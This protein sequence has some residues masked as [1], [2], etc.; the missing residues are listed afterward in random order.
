[1]REQ[2]G[3]PT[4][5][6]DAGNIRR[7][8][9]A[10]RSGRLVVFPTET[11]YGLGGD[12]ASDAA[13]AAIFA[14]KGRPAFNPLII[15][16]ENAE[17]AFALGDAT[18]EARR[19]AARFWPGPLSL[20][21]R[22]RPDA[23]VSLLA[24]A[25]LE[26]IAV[27]VPSHPVA[28]ALLREFGGGIAAPSANI[29]GR[30]SPTRPQHI[31]LPAPDIA[32][33]LVGDP[34]TV[35]L[36]STVIACLPDT[37][38]SMLRPGGIP[39]E[40]IEIPLTTATSESETPSSPGMLTHHYAPRAPLR[41]NATSMRNDELLLAFG[42]PLPNARSTCNL[43]PSADLREAAANLFA[44]LAHLD[45]EATRLA[46]AAHTSDLPTIAVMPIPNRDLGRAINDRLTRAA[47]G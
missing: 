14:V 32:H 11:V 30:L 27:R 39:L 46:E 22:R 16:V 43:S 3:I 23:P 24:T 18:P 25:G 21:L 17:A 26:T 41:L 36:E 42:T 47:R 2:E 28:R 33:I 19:L 40:N 7:A 10:L 13:V 1:M 35:G 12:A 4:L 5:P 29:S 44:H 38:V 34:P 20:V 8:A 37:P 6:S 9:E 31:T 15:H 45:A